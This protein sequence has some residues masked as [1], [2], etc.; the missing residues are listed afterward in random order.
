MRFIHF[1]FLC[2]FFGNVAAHEESVSSNIIAVIDLKKVAKDSKAGQDIQRQIKQLQDKARENLTSFEKKVKEID[3]KS[4]QSLESRQRVEDLSVA[5]Y[6]MTRDERTRLQNLE[7]SAIEKMNI[8][9]E[10]II[11]DVIK[12]K[13]IAL[14]IT[15]DAV[16]QKSPKCMDITKIVIKRLDEQ[17]PKVDIITEDAQAKEQ[18]DDR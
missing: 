8:E 4:D 9:V 5:M 2:F 3:S 14:V 13:N 17:M 1:I 12:E 6:K 11:K 7:Q 18:S 10:E 15:N 16:V